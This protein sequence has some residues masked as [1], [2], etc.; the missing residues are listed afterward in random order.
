MLS[1]FRNRRFGNRGYVCKS[2]IILRMCKTKTRKRLHFLFV[3]LNKRMVS[4]LGRVAQ[5]DNLKENRA[6][7]LGM[8][9]GG[10]H[11]EQQ[12]EGNRLRAVLLL[13]CFYGSCFSP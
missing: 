13:L 7:R 12:K 4:D 11:A 2:T 5:V 8:R 3:S 10:H 1:Q 6:R 9:V